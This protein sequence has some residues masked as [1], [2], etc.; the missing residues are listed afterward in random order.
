[1][2]K[3]AYAFILALAVVI[4]AAMAVPAPA[5]ASM[6]VPQAATRML[7]P[8]PVAQRHRRSTGRKIACTPAGCHPIPRGCY[9]EPA[10]DFWGNPTGF[11]KIVCPRR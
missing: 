10:F 3:T 5:A 8:I 7:A 4:P 9:P 2:P 11:D 1:M 6:A